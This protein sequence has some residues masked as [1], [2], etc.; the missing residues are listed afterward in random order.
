[1]RIAILS[2][3]HRS[4]NYTTMFIALAL[5]LCIAMQLLGVPATMWMPD[6]TLDT[7]GSSVSEGFSIPP[8]IVP[9][10]QLVVITL[11]VA[12]QQ[13]FHVPLLSRSLFHP[14]VLF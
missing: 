2:S 7:F 6:P 14:P 11:L 8:A 1:M 10:V 4:H 5:S 3:A 9:V 13:T 12:F